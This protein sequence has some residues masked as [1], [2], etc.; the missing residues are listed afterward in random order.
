MVLP[1]I[2]VAVLFV[3]L[4]ISYPWEVLSVA[5]VAYLACLP[6][7]WHYYQQ[8]RQADAAAAKPAAVAAPAE[9]DTRTP[10]ATPQQD[11][12]RPARLN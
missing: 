6:L 3:V 12:D 9:A 4:L 11:D 5:T 1:V 8:Y 2:I 7:G 10:S